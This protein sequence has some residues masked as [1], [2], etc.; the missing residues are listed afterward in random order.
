LEETLNAEA[1]GH[2]VSL[3][4]SVARSSSLA[5]LARTIDGTQ[6][7]GGMMEYM[8][9]AAPESTLSRATLVQAR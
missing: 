8:D 4:R 3:D 7:L 5:K 1:I 2:S 6:M 9:A